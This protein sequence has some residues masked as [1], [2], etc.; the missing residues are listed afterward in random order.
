MNIWQGF[1]TGLSVGVYCIGV[2]LPM[3]VPILLA[4]R[5]KKHGVITQAGLFGLLQKGP[6]KNSIRPAGI[7]TASNCLQTHFFHQGKIRLKRLPENRQGG[8]VI[9]TP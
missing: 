8:R 4:Q 3:V 1:L 5:H 9:L 2:C 6:Q 7:G